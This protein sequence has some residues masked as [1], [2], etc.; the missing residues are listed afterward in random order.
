M[1]SQPNLYRSRLTLQGGG[2]SFL[3]AAVLFLLTGS[4]AYFAL[5]PLGALAGFGLG[6]VLTGRGHTAGPSSRDGLQTAQKRLPADWPLVV[7]VAGLLAAGAVLL[8]LGWY[9][10][11]ALPEGALRGPTAGDLLPTERASSLLGALLPI[12]IWNLALA[13]GVALL[14]LLLAPYA[15]GCLLPLFWCFY[16]GLLLGNNSLGL[17][18]PGRMAPSLAIFER[19]GPYEMIALLLIAAASIV[20]LRPERGQFFRSLP[21]LL[22]PTAWAAAG[23]GVLLLVFANAREVAMILAR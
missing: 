21:R 23:L 5:I 14:N 1:G 17:A 4:L 3:L 15:F 10:G 7:R 6:S 8:L 19:S 2:L 9:L 11:Y 18:L 12:L 22:S 13:A 20:H 16:Y